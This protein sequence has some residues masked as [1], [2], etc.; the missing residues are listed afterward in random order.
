MTASSQGDR[1]D[2]RLQI[3]NI[4]TSLRVVLA[5]ALF[6]LLSVWSYTGSPVVRGAG[7]DW[8]LLGAA[9]LFI[10]AA[11][12][13]ALDGHLARKWKAVSVFGRIMDPF[14]DKLLVIGTFTFM[15]APAFWA[16]SVEGGG[17]QVSGVHAWMV[18]VVLGRELL[19]TS[20]RGAMEGAGVA[21]SASWSGK[22]KMILQ[23]FV[24]P[25]V[26]VLLATVRVL[27][28][29]SGRGGGERPWAGMVIDVLVWGTVIVTAWSG[30][31]YVTRAAAVARGAGKSEK[32]GATT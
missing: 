11:I 23:S 28:E 10:L 3:P 2:L 14:A 5:C 17:R 29:V 24:I 22:M 7:V 21:F 9:G 31:P 15:A 13:D 8:M 20:I 4:L 12:T 25:I 32:A 18:A 6:A 16:P 27:P 30:W 26:L 19:V 1:G